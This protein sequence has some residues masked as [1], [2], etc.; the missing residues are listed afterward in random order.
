MFASYNYLPD[1]SPDMTLEEKRQ[2][3]SNR[4]NAF[5]ACIVTQ[6]ELVP[7]LVQVK[8]HTNEG[9]PKRLS[10]QEVLGEEYPSVMTELLK[11]YECVE[12]KT[13][14][15]EVEAIVDR[16]MA[17]YG[18]PAEVDEEGTE[19]C[20]TPATNPHCQSQEQGR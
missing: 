20:A 5:L 9:R 8:S 6:G 17:K 1:L 7:C 4:L 14:S 15:A 19:E 3:L 2:V 13:D 12:D 18:I 16:L 10:L 11:R